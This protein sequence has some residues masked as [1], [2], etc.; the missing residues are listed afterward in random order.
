MTLVS[1]I[2]VYFILLW[3]V[4]FAVLPFGIRSQAEEGEVVEGTE[5]AAPV[6]PMI[7]RKLIATTI[8]AGV[9]LGAYIGVQH[10]GLTLDDIPFL[11]DF[12][13]TGT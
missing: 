8:I 11:P 13:S 6:K 10:L 5:P 7:V 9:V 2:A 1:G 12:K 3:L 4:L